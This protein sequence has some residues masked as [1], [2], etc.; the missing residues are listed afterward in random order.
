MLVMIA[1]S[2]IGLEEGRVGSL[3]DWRWGGV[4][5]GV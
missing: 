4:V 3:P 1:L 5:G 2:V